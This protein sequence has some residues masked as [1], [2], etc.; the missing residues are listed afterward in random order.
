MWLLLVSA[1][2][3]IVSRVKA[4]ED[5]P[6]RPLETLN[7]EHSSVSG[8]SPLWLLLMQDCWAQDPWQRPQFSEIILRLTIISGGK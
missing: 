1:A 6:F 5:P 8:Q 4:G 3:V 7:A 2:V